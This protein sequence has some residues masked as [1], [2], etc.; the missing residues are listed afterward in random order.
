MPYRGQIISNDGLHPS[1]KVC[2][3]LILALW[4]A[5][6]QAGFLPES[7]KNRNKNYSFSWG[8]KQ[9]QK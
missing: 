4:S 8:P 9:L 5:L 6:R 3:Y 7:Y 1:L 2:E